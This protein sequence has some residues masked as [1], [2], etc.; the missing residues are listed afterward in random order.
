[1][2]DEYLR[3]KVK[4]FLLSLWSFCHH[5]ALASSALKSVAFWP[6]GA[7]RCSRGRLRADAT[8]T[9]QEEVRIC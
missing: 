5:F 3:F 4:F 8:W 9:F 6:G 7:A 1:M 2:A